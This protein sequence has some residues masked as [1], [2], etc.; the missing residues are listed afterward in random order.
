MLRR[1][2]EALRPTRHKPRLPA[3][4]RAGPAAAAS[5]GRALPR[6]RGRTAASA[7]LRAHEMT[8]ARRS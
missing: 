5:P 3:H 1:V 8:A 2:I 7:W 6:P 4:L